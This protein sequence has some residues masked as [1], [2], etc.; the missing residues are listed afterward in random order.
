MTHN[1][2]NKNF[3]LTKIKSYF[4]LLKHVQFLVLETPLLSKKYIRIPSFLRIKKLQN[5]LVLSKNNNLKFNTL[6]SVWLKFF[7]KPFKKHLLLKGLGFKGVIIT[8]SS[9]EKAVLEL[10]LGFSHFIKLP[11]DLKKFKISLNNNLLTVEGFNPHEVG[12]FLE[13]IKKL[14]SIDNYKGKGFWYKN[15]VRILKEIKKI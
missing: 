6:L 8:D 14:K 10:K 2:Y 15:E 5:S 7:L 13:K 9:T 1:S 3:L 11:L 12:N 4:I